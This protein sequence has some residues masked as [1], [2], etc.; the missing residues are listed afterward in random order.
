MRCLNTSF[1]LHELICQQ[2]K[3]T[4]SVESPVGLSQVVGHLRRLGQHDVPLELLILLW[5]TLFLLAKMEQLVQESWLLGSDSV[6][7]V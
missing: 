4:R 6:E 1:P 3:E 2:F 5:R 7:K